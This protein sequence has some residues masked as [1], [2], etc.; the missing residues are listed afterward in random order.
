VLFAAVCLLFAAI[1]GNGWG[2]ALAGA[3]VPV[4]LCVL[5][6]ARSSQLSSDSY[7]APNTQMTRSDGSTLSVSPQVFQSADATANMMRLFAEFFERKPLPPPSG[8]V[9]SDLSVIQNSSA[10][11]LR[12]IDAMNSDQTNTRELLMQTGL[13][14][15]AGNEHREQVQWRGAPPTGIGQPTENS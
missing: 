10:D 2:I 4:M 15:A 1:T 13:A 11:A 14:R 5:Y 8:M 3:M 9:S 7:D 6:L 12:V